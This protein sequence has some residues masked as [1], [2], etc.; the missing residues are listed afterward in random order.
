MEFCSWP[1]NRPSTPATPWRPRRRSISRTCFLS[2]LPSP[3]ACALL[4]GCRVC[5][6]V[7]VWVG[8]FVCVCVCLCASRSCVHVCVCVCGSARRRACRRDDGWSSHPSP[9]LSRSAVA[10][11]R[12]GAD[13][14]ENLQLVRVRGVAVSSSMHRGCA[15]ACEPV[16]HTGAT[17]LDRP[18]QGDQ[19]GPKLEGGSAVRRETRRA[20]RASFTCLR[21]AERST[22]CIRCRMLDPH[23][24]ER[25]LSCSL[26]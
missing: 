19:R 15:M 23:H 21:S 20:A 10:G 1:P 26:P 18:A 16:D 17:N 9:H 13:T 11:V 25:G 2:S 5:V 3:G 8:G 6:F 4:P 7:C 12:M 24:Q 14:L 22:P